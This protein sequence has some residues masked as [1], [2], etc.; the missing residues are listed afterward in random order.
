MSRLLGFLCLSLL[1]LSL[2]PASALGGHGHHCWGGWGGISFGVGPGP[3]YGY[4][5]PRFHGSSFYGGGCYPYCAGGYYGAYNPYGIYYAPYYGYSDY[6]LPPVFAPA[7]LLY[8]PRAVKQFLGIN[9]QPLVLVRGDRDFAEKPKVRVSNPE[10]RRKAD[11][12]LAQG[13]RLFREQKY[14]QAIDR[15]KQAG[16]MAPDVAEIQWR[17]GHAYV[18][19]HRYDLAA[20]AFKRGLSLAPDVHRDGFNLTTLYGP[21]ATVKASHLEALAGETLAHGDSAELHFLLGIFL[22]YDGQS[23]RAAKFFLRAR[24]LAGPGADYLTAFL[25]RDADGVPVA[26]KELEI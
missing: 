21:G 19:T 2:T 22:R 16:A 15:Y 4:Y 20:S 8:G 9:D 3:V 18:A 1:A 23:E 14:A 12:F 13:D 11:Q 25:I 5:R 7:E 17:K 10:Y 6:Y 24:E 26:A